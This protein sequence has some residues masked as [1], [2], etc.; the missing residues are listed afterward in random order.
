MIGIGSGVAATIGVIAPSADVLTQMG[1]T[2]AVGGTI[3]AVI[4]KRIEVTDLPQLV[5]LFH[6]FVG[7][8]AVLTSIASYMID[9]SK[10]RI[11]SEL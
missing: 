10:I 11:R 7:A 4:A 3:G 2:M 6:S 8:A 9:A 5:A 1:L